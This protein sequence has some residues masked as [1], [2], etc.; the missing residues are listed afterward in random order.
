MSKEINWNGESWIV[1]SNT[2]TIYKKGKIYENDS[3]LLTTGLKI[4]NY[5]YSNFGDIIYFQRNTDNEY[6]KVENDTIINISKE[7]YLE[8]KKMKRIIPENPDSI[9]YVMNYV[10]A[11]I[12][13]DIL[14]REYQLKT[15]IPVD[16]SNIVTV[17]SKNFSE[18]IKSRIK[19]VTTHIMLYLPGYID[20]TQAK[21][22][23]YDG[24]IKTLDDNSE[25]IENIEKNIIQENKN[26]FDALADQIK[27]SIESRKK[28]D[29]ISQSRNLQMGEKSLHERN[30]DK[31]Q[32]IARDRIYENR[33][34]PTLSEI[35]EKTES[36]SKGRRK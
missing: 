7:E 32:Q 34:K 12:C 4:G 17:V 23:I 19:E 16:N 31:F 14:K 27:L 3:E 8:Y 15:S 5:S 26:I 11:I 36:E 9:R 28:M 25:Y 24:F 35:T 1:D 21:K 18:I 2:K 20:R 33:H 6:F 22:V 30:Y 29:G 13:D 10:I